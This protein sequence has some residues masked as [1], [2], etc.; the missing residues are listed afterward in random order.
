MVDE[1]KEGLQS[2]LSSAAAPRECKK[3]VTAE[4]AALVQIGPNRDPGLLGS[5]YADLEVYYDAAVIS[6]L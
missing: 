2:A 6:P 5:M 4:T 3:Q 1:R